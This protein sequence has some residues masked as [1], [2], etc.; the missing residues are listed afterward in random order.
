LTPPHIVLASIIVAIL[1]AGGG[2]WFARTQRAALIA[3]IPGRWIEPDDGTFDAADVALAEDVDAQLAN[4]TDAGVVAWPELV[5]RNNM[6]GTALRDIASEVGAAQ[7]LVVLARDVA[8]RT[9]VNVFL[10]DEP[11]GRKRLALS[12]D[13][14]PLATEQQRR[15]LAARIALDL[16][17]RAAIGD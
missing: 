3:P 8:R 5:R 1:A 6:R 10:I 12:Y 7:L 11:A 4:R 16:H 13:G 14:P 17:L 2:Y 15:S 9:R